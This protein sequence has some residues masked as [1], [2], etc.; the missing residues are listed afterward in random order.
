MGHVLTQKQVDTIE[1]IADADGW[2][3]RAY[4]GRGMMG[5]S[6][7]LAVV[8][9]ATEL[10]NFGAFLY[11]EDKELGAVLMSFRCCLDSM[12]RDNDVAYWPSISVTGTSLDDDEDDE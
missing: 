7:C 5:G 9:T 8:L 10:F 6:P 11:E 4:H 2:K 3:V 12:G 1:Q